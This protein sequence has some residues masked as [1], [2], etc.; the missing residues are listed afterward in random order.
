VHNPTKLDQDQRR[1][2]KDP[3]E[4]EAQAHKEAS[5]EIEEGPYNPNH[6]TKESRVAKLR[7][8]RGD[9][10]SS[11]EAHTHTLSTQ[12]SLT[13]SCTEMEAKAFL[14]LFHLFIDT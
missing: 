7:K 14:L 12:S 13:H 6:K 3:E 1:D 2:T 11:R 9:M 8:P 4:E 10:A 5:L